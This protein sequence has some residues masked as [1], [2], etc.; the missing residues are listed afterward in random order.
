TPRDDL[1]LALV[2]V[3]PISSPGSDVF[4]HPTRCSTIWRLMEWAQWRFDVAHLLPSGQ[5]GRNIHE[6]TSVSIHEVERRLGVIVWPRLLHLIDTITRHSGHGFCARRRAAGLPGDGEELRARGD[7]AVRP[8]MG[9][10]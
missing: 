4:D 10:K 9:R 8:R 2:G 5:Y 6:S 7:D 3:E 1:D